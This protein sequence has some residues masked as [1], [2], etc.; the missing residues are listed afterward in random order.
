MSKNFDTNTAILKIKERFDIL[1]REGTFSEK[2]GNR[3]IFEII[4]EM[5][6]RNGRSLATLGY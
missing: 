4:D 1:K 2:A 6:G 5:L 3:V